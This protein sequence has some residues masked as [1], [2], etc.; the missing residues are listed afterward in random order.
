VIAGGVAA[1]QMLRARLA[2]LLDQKGFRLI[3]PHG[4]WCTDNAVMIAWAGIERLSLG[5]VDALTVAA[6]ARWPLDDKAAVIAHNR[7]QAVR[8]AKGD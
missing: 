4:K 6:R 1:N 7:A 8:A 3:A 2:H 5:L